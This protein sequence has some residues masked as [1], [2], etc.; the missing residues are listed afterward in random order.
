AAATFVGLAAL[1]LFSHIDWG[2]LVAVPLVAEFAFVL[3]GGVVLA[4]LG[5]LFIAL[6]LAVWSDKRT[7]IP[8]VA[9]A[10][11]AADAKPGAGRTIAIADNWRGVVFPAAV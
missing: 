6:P 8:V 2:P 7:P 4:W 1:A 5:A 3:C 11:D 10:E 9:P